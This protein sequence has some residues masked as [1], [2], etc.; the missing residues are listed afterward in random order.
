VRALNSSV[1]LMATSA[2]FESA[3]PDPGPHLTVQCVSFLISRKGFT[4][5]VLD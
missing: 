4:L 3:D 5:L 2:F 1:T